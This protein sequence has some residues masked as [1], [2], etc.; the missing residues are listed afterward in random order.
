MEIS[1][2]FQ[3]GKPCRRRHI[4]YGQPGQ[5][6]PR[7]PLVIGPNSLGLCGGTGQSEE[8]WPSAV[9]VRSLG[10][11]AAATAAPGAVAG[12]GGW[13]VSEAGGHGVGF[14]VGGREAAPR[15]RGAPGRLGGL[16]ATRE[17]GSSAGALGG[18]VRRRREDA[19]AKRGGQRQRESGC[20]DR[21]VRGARGA[22]AS[23]LPAR[24]AD[25]RAALAA[26][27]RAAWGHWAPRG[28]RRAPSQ[29]PAAP[30]RPAR[31]P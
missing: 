28:V 10:G 15:R 26:A 25:A 29:V 1:L 14:G 3:A 11:A 27:A 12:W 7:C 6:S 30:S 17:G 24:A 31:P 13:A 19:E 18:C 4:H 16:A 22:G 20:G 23:P 5:A 8:V 9:S 21:T 2:S